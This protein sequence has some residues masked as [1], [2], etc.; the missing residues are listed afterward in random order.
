MRSPQHSIPMRK[1]AFPIG[2]SKSVPQVG[3]A[4]MIR[5][6]TN[7]R[8]RKVIIPVTGHPPGYARMS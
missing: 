5:H 7:Q 1:K 2:Y 4:I 6:G 8:R 3:Q